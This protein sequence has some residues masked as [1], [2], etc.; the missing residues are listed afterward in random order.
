M[1]KTNGKLSHQLDTF[2]DVIE[3]LGGLKETSRLTRRSTSQIC[4]WRTKFGAFPPEHYVTISKGLM[5]KG[6]GAPL[7]LFK[8]ERPSE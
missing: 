2:D 3:K 4:Q 1:S 8:F 7:H 6:Y 5:A